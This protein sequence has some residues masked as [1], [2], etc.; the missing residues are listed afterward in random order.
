GVDLDTATDAPVHSALDGTVVA[1]GPATGFGHWIVIDSSTSTGTVSTVYGHMYDDGLRVRQGDVVRAG[2]HIAD[3]GNDGQSSGAHLHF[4]VWEGGRLQGGRAVDPMP[5]L[6]GSEPSDQSVVNAISAIA[7]CAGAGDA[8]RPGLVPAEYVPWLV[9]AGSICPGITAPLLAAQIEQESGFRD[10]RSPAG[11]Q[12]PAQFMPGTW[13]THG[14]DGDNDGVENVH[15]IPDAVISQGH[16]MCERQE[17]ARRECPGC[18]PVDLAL[19]A[20]DTGRTSAEC[21]RTRGEPYVATIHRRARV[22]AGG[23]PSGGTYT[24]ETQPYTPPSNRVVDVALAQQGKPY[25]WGAE[26]GTQPESF[27]GPGLT[28]YAFGP[29]GDGAPVLPPTVGQ[30]WQ[31]G[32]AVASDQ[33]VRGDLVFSDFDDN[34]QPRRVGISVG[35]GNVLEARPGAGVGVH[36][37]EQDSLAK[38]IAS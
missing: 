14:K 28:A 25:E 21:L 33:V 2:Q 8:A 30:Q 12:G 7:D 3:V 15:S 31:M 17:E 37:V 32:V 34:A 4:E 18:S 5:V 11:A 27:D 10:A 6:R 36:P 19:T 35:E 20:Y 13:A 9:R 16:L 38:R 24:T 1:A 23:L 26:G 22:F 29:A